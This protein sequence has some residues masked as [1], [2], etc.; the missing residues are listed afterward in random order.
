VPLRAVS[1]VAGGIGAIGDVAGMVHRT[2]VVNDRLA[3]ANDRVN[4]LPT[5]ATPQQVAG[6]QRNLSGAQFA[7]QSNSVRNASDV[8]QSVTSAAGEN[9]SVPDISNPGWQ[10]P[11]STGSGSG[12]Y[13]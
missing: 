9:G 13:T 2:G 12:L 1:D 8:G 4:N 10:A 7:Q 6:A 3:T 5:T 11:N